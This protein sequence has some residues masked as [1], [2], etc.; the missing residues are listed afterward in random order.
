MEEYKNGVNCSVERRVKEI[1]KNLN[2][3]EEEDRKKSRVSYSRISNH[4]NFHVQPKECSNCA[5]IEKE[6]A[7][8]MEHI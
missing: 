8:Q 4:N 2:N 6:T 3:L 5:R 7:I 1:A